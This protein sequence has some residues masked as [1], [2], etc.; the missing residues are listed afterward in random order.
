MSLGKQESTTL[1]PCITYIFVT[2]TC[3]PVLPALGRQRQ[4]LANI[5]TGWVISSPWCLVPMLYWMFSG[6]QELLIELSILCPVQL[7]CSILSNSLWLHG[8]QQASLPCPPL[9]FRV[10][11]NSSSLSQWCSPTISSCIV[12]FSSCLQ[13]SRASGS[14]LMSQL[15]TSGGQSIEVSAWASVLPMNIPLW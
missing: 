11:S 15:F 1:G 2:V 14:F 4:R 7:S 12:P 10:C 8:L 5:K 6:G 3:V 9:S 13:S